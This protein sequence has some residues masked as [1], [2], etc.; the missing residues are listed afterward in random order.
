MVQH[1]RDNIPQH[2]WYA[3]DRLSVFRYIDYNLLNAL[4][5]ADAEELGNSIELADKLTNTFLLSW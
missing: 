3:F 1:V 4:T 5:E 2:L